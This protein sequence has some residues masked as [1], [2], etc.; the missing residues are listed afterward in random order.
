VGVSDY[1]ATG[2][3]SLMPFAVAGARERAKVDIQ[4]GRCNA[5]L[6]TVH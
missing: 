1:S 5:V 6:E 3:A 2:L 4:V